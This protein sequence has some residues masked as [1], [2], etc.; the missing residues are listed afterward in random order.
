MHFLLLLL[1]SSSSLT[2]H[3]LVRQK[4]TSSAFTNVER[5]IESWDCINEGYHHKE[6]LDPAH[7]TSMV[8]EAR[9]YL[10]G[11]TAKP[12]WSPSDSLFAQELASSYLVIR[13]EFD[14]V[15]AISNSKNLA[16]GNNVWATAADSK[17]AASYGPDWKTLV[18]NDRTTYDSTNSLLFPKTVSILKNLTGTPVV[19]AF[20]ASMEP[21]SSINLHSDS[22][23]FI[24]TS[25][26]GLDIPGNG[27]ECRLS[28]GDTTQNWKDGEVMLFDTSIM[29]SAVNETPKTRYILMLRVWHPELTSSEIKALQF[30]FD[31]LDV[32]G[33]LSESAGERFI[34]EEQLRVLRS[35]EGA[36]P[37][38]PPTTIPTPSKKSKKSATVIKRGFG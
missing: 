12:F 23:N 9:S 19:E 11:L 7:P 8:Q 36:V 18:L 35:G 21:N 3:S 2:F 6:I 32:P 16:K 22:C 28:V 31:A 17:S 26:L 24:L 5:V 15:T 25:H 14:K 34:A 37:N 33:I 27:N 13:E 4:L 20:F 10:P 29:H 1:P 30:T 38:P